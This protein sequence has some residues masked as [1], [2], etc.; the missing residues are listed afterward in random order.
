MLKIRSEVRVDQ[1]RLTRPDI[2]EGSAPATYVARRE[3][4]NRDST[5]GRCMQEVSAVLVENER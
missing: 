4:L 1:R 5:S 2:R 3:I